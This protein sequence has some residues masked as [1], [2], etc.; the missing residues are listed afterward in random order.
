MTFTNGKG[1]IPILFLNQPCKSNLTQSKGV[2]DSTTMAS[3]LNEDSVST[4]NERSFPY[5]WTVD[6]NY[7]SI[8]NFTSAKWAFFHDADDN[9][10][11]DIYLVKSEQGTSY[12]NVSL[13][14][15]NLISPT[16][17]FSVTGVVIYNSSLVG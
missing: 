13:L 14:Y 15:N 9:G 8:K 6:K 17:G 7:E 1:S 3:I 2:N 11:Q 4:C 12:L 10:I 5:A 16:D